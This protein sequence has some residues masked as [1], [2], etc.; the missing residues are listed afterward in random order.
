MRGYS[1]KS[2]WSNGVRNVLHMVN[3]RSRQ[4]SN[5]PETNLCQ[6]YIAPRSISSH[7]EMDNR[8]RRNVVVGPQKVGGS[9]LCHGTRT[10]SDAKEKSNGY[11]RPDPSLC[12]IDT[13]MESWSLDVWLSGG[14]APS[15]VAISSFFSTCRRAHA[16]EA[17]R[18]AGTQ[19][20]VDP[21]YK[22]KV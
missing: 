1:D 22:A 3:E 18:F 19:G 13:Q 17:R 6:E 5:C 20:Y 15:D 14:T 11:I 10:T 8:R 9:T 12:K 7:R 4:R 16:M 2:G 21:L